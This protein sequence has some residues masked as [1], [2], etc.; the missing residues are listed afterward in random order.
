MQISATD[1]D[2]DTNAQI[3]YTLHGPGADEFKL[4]P[5]TGGFPELQPLNHL[6]IEYQVPS[7]MVGSL[8]K[9]AGI[10]LSIHPFIQQTC[11]LVHCA[12]H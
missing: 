11:I 12:K 7:I 2:S 9:E 8:G 6:F 3:T 4:D 10:N 5:H 1:L